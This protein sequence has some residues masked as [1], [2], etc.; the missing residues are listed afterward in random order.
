VADIAEVMLMRVRT[1]SL[2]IAVGLASTFAGLAE[3][4]TVGMFTNTGSMTYAREYHTATLLKTGS[5]LVAGGLG[6]SGS[7]LASAELYN[8]A[9]ASFSVT[10]SL[11]VAR[12]GQTAT[13]LTNGSVLIAGGA[14][15][16]GTL[17]SA[18]LYNPS[19][20]SF[21]LTG[22]MTAA[23]S[24]HT[25][26][27]LTN[28]MVLI[29]GGCNTSCLSSAELYNPSTGTFTATTGNMTR[30][31][32]SHTATL[33][34]NG[35]VLIAGG[36]ASG[37]VS[38]TAETYNPSTETF[39]AT[40]GN[41]TAARE[42]QT[43]TLLNNG[44]V[45]IAGGFNTASLASAELYNPSTGTFS[46]TGSLSTA[47]DYHTA[48]LLP[49]GSVLIAGGYNSGSAGAVSGAELY[50]PSAG[51]FSGTGSL[52]DARTG[53]TA[54]LLPSGLVLAAGGFD[55][56]NFTASAELYGGFSGSFSVTSS[57]HTARTYHT[58][59]LLSNGKV[60]IVG[61]ANG[62]TVLSSAEIYDPTSGTF[63]STTGNL[64]TPRE[65]HTASLLWDGTVLIAG[66]YSGSA[67]L[68]TA[69]IYNPTSGT[70]SYTSGHMVK[71][72]A[73]GAAISLSS[74]TSVLLVG[75]NNC[76]SGCYIDN[77]ELYNPTA[78]TFS[79][80]SAMHKER[81]N[82][83][84]TLLANIGVVLEAG[85]LNCTGC[86]LQYAETYNPSTQNFTSVSN[87]ISQREYHAAAPLNNSQ[88]YTLIA[89]GLSGSGALSAAELY[90][91][92]TSGFVATGSM[93]AARYNH[94]ATV[95]GSGAVLVAGGY[96]G[97]SYLGSAEMYVNS[98][99]GPFQST[100]SLHTAR[101][102][103]TATLLNNGTVLI[104]G[105][106]NSSGSL[107]SAE[108]YTIA[109]PLPV[110]TNL[111]LT[112]GAVG[113]SVTINGANFGS[114]QGTSTATFNGTSA[115]VASVWSP[116]AVTVTVPAGATTG[117]VVVTVP[118]AGASNGVSFTVVPAPS[119]SSLSA[120]FG[121]V[122]SPVTVYGSNFGSTQGSGMVLFNGTVAGVTSWGATSIG[123]TVP[124]GATTGNVVV[125]ASGVTSNG[126]PF[127]V[128][129]SIEDLNPTSAAA[130]QRV[131]ITGANFGSP[132]G[133][134]TVTFNGT[135]AG[136]AVAWSLNNITVNVPPGATTGNVIVT[137]GGQASNGV[138]FTVLPT[139]NITSLSVNS[140]PAGT[141]VTISGTNFGSPQGS[142]MVT[143]NGLSAGTASSWS[144]GSISVNVPSG[145]TTGS[146]VVTV[147]GVPSAG[148][149]FTVTS[150]AITGLSQS[151]AEVGVSITI[152]GA[153]FGSSQ[154]S[155]TVTFNG[156]SAGTAGNW[157][158]NSI[159]VNVPTGATTGNVVV[160]VSGVASNGV[161]FT[162][163]PTP[164][165]TTVYY[166]IQD[167]LGSTRVITDSSGNLCYDAD[168]YPFGGERVYT[169]TCSQN[170]KF[171][172]QERDSES[173]LDDFPA[174]S[175]SSQW[176]RFMS[177]DLFGG[178][179]GDPQTLN[180]YSYVRNNPGTLV[181]PTGLDGEDGGGFGGCFLGCGGP[182]GPIW[183][184][185]PT[186][187]S[188]GNVPSF[189]RTA[190]G[191]I[192]W[193]T[194]IFGPPPP[195]DTCDW[196]TNSFDGTQDPNDPNACSYYP[197]NAQNC[198]HP[199]DPGASYCDDPGVDCGSTSDAGAPPSD[200]GGTSRRVPNPYYA[201]VSD[202]LS[203]AAVVSS[204]LDRVGL[205]YLG[206]AISVWND[207]SPTNIAL[208]AA[209]FIPVVGEGVTAGQA[210][211]DVGMLVGD[212]FEH[213]IVGP[214][215]NAA[216]PQQIDD[217]FGGRIPNPAL[218]DPCHAL[219]GCN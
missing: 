24:G 109:P 150:P 199:K 21:T 82:F 182:A 188:L 113:A 99:T 59:T 132:Q 46:A 36:V 60:L 12:Q 187:P 176:G 18:E 44:E 137:V 138:S 125:M 151:A 41:M 211:Y 124:L 162:V 183:Q 192:D 1:W 209:G 136:T 134:S 94:T 100:G 39:T 47:R 30:T 107:S 207:P 164:G 178:Y 31:R 62:S 58:A 142:S 147:S 175:F 171:T 156:T 126:V 152:S 51:T 53:H 170:Y 49:T 119:I 73:A 179:I 215:F 95:L 145:A 205:G 173:N 80:V 216:P 81:A 202:A 146:V 129:P 63:S 181:D 197:G 50:N 106:T 103:H 193:S 8:P 158:S 219:G 26:T 133:S 121:A 185:G 72:R 19:N 105:G 200:T 127:T 74:G 186:L 144:A 141:P 195:I 155:N 67:Y 5:V 83:T 198:N 91:T 45:L 22:S 15:S 13:L 184:E 9:T 38:A 20:G 122:G 87:M 4:Q 123:V 140:G 84:Q 35:T 102:G 116:T 210:L 68:N 23:R 111:S 160:T 52:Y 92:A 48:T 157:G 190:S 120:N 166:Y 78:Q 17:S 114:A 37:T 204:K 2:A 168:F 213:D 212:F 90:N 110:I 130:G 7:M 161:P 167:T 56:V 89:G 14:N 64:N 194:L 169:N 208:T 16:S 61:G 43:A 25:A 57:L 29:T 174:R 117:N 118:A 54:T 6:T 172:G 139:P 135:S 206:A 154:G 159:T 86:Y 33:L 75:G 69:E 203:I 196:C 79:S 77:A 143:F 191:G 201:V 153:D 180:H 218:V 85:G 55:L 98:S 27:L 10:G 65:Y 115:G 214:M 104:A 40:T 76:S 93:A 11:N 88:Q 3:A 97:S 71:E 217:G 70:F 128:A 66:G 96:N 165:P 32:S 42:L 149:L 108:L 28:G 112:T 131:T 177:P 101:S 34:T 148:V 163:L 189:P